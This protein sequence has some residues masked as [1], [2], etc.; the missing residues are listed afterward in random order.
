MSDLGAWLAS[1]LDRPTGVTVV[2]G[3]VTDTAPFSVA[4]AGSTTAVPDIARLSSYTPALND[5]VAVLRIGP[6]SLVLGAIV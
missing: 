2:L 5:K 3:S 4:L 6:A 1:A